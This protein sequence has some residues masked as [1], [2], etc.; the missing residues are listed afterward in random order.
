MLICHSVAEI[1]AFTDEVRG[2][3]EQLVVDLTPAQQRF[4]PHANVWCAGEIVEH[5]AVMEKRL[6][7]LIASIVNSAAAAPENN[8]AGFA[9]VSLDRFGGQAAGKMEAPEMVR[10]GGEV[11]ISDSLAAM[12]ASRA[13]LAE[14]R[15]QIEAR[16]F[17]AS[18]FQHPFFGLL[19]VYEWLLLLGVH[20]KRHLKQIE[21][22]IAAPGFPG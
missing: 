17:S 6:S 21:N 14:L 10:P 19:N 2:C 9:P 8:R 7:R 22:L 3:L 11:S 1:Y 20:E 15:P 13:A 16:D 4:K 18:A 5:L 12:R